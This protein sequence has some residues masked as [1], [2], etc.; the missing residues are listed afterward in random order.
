MYIPLLGVNE[1][2]N[3]VSAQIKSND[4]ALEEWKVEF[5]LGFLDIKPSQIRICS[6][7]LSFKCLATSRINFSMN[8]D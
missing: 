6:V 3:E 8:E 7:L 2:V 4:E 1:R 5:R